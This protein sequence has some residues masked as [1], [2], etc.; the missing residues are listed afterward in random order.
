MF[1]LITGTG[2][3]PL[4]ERSVTS[5]VVAVATH[6]VIIIVVIAIPLLRVTNQLPELPTMRAFL[7]FCCSGPK[8]QFSL[9][10]RHRSHTRLSRWSGKRNRR[11]SRWTLAEFSTWSTPRSKCSHKLRRGKVSMA[12]NCGWLV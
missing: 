7:D 8:V 2:E 4:R 3:R 10:M 6:A 12:F 11:S 9:P 1:D 5:K